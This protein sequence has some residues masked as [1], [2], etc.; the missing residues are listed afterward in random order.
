VPAI[1]A[2]HMLDTLKRVAATLRDEGIPFAV[3]GG[4][5][6][7]ARGGPPTET[8]IDLLI[9]EADAEAALAALE[10]TGMRVERP[11]E[12]WLV[13]AYDGDLLVDLIYRPSGIVVDERYLAQCDEIS[14]NAVPMRVMPVVDL[15]VTKLL[16][17]TEHH[18]D[19]GPVL[20]VARALREQ[21]DWDELWSRCQ[22]SPF[23]RAFF[24]LVRELGVIGPS[25]PTTTL[26]VPA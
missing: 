2:E 24:A 19:Y 17:L 12:G 7:W 16:S 25:A 9:R 26:A 11:P 3:G 23:A 8:D 15:V 5:A 10:A 14:V 4:L 13:K 21:I 18:L 6:A 1:Q 20:E 22:A